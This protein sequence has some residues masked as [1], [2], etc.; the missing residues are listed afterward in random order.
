MLSNMVLH[1]FSNDSQ[2][3]PI[4]RVNCL[5]ILQFIELNVYYVF[6]ALYIEYVSDVKST[7]PFTHE[8]NTWICLRQWFRSKSFKNLYVYISFKEVCLRIW[9]GSVSSQIKCP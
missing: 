2:K 7:P 1:S 5:S 3:Q 4:I 8:S 9:K 6:L